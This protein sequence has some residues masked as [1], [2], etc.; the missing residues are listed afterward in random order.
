MTQS[1]SPLHQM[2]TGY[3]GPQIDPATSPENPIQFFESWFNEAWSKCGDETNFMMLATANE[4]AEPHVRTVLLKKF[5]ENG[6]VFFT[7][8]ESEKGHDLNVNPMASLLFHWQ[9]LF[10]Q[11]RI[12]GHVEKTNAVDSAAYFVSR[13]FESRISAMASPQSQPIAS[14]AELENQVLALTKKYN[15]HHPP[16]PSFWGG[17][18]V[19]PQKIEFWQGRP[20]RLHDRVLYTKTNNGWSKTRLAP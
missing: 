19:I 11:I 15:H 1:T 2:R 9:P 6:F 16:C 18:R 14:R 3:D 8:Y 10:R 12:N 20:D 4:H 13:P 17:Y 5:D 7:N